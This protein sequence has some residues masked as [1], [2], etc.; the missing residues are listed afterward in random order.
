MH[1]LFKKYQFPSKQI[2]EDLLS[3]TETNPNTTITELGILVEN[4]Y[5]VDVL[6]CN[7]LPI[8]WEYYEINNIENNGYHTYLGWEFKNNP[9]L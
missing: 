6:W 3:K 4:M 1:L 9:S 7:Q 8:D 5:S 2:F